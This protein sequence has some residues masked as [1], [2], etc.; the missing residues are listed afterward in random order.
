MKL[1]KLA[2]AS[3]AAQATALSGPYASL[4]RELATDITAAKVA[5]E[6][7]KEAKGGIWGGFKNAITASIEAE[8][9]A[10]AM[11]VGLEVACEEAGIPSGT[12]RGYVSTLCSLKADVDNAVLSL[13]QALSI[14]IK[15]ARELYADAD[16][17][18]RKALTD[19]LNAAVKKLDAAA[20]TELVE[21]AE[22]QA[23]T[24]VTTVVPDV[25]QV[26]QAA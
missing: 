11:R 19:R 23:G 25:Q 16:K 26:A 10:N 6:T 14:S 21:L 17:K 18:A 3:L 12:F 15:D 13:E 7:A 8:H 4:A 9:D 22:A 5:G 24:T 2:L 1:S 20:L